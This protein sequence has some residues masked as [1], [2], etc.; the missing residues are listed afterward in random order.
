MLL[1]TPANETLPKLAPSGEYVAYQTD[2]T[3]R[4]EIRVRPFPE[5]EG[6]WQVSVNG[7]E[8]PTWSRE[9]DELFYIEGNRMMA[10][11]IQ[12]AEGFQAGAPR[13]LFTGDDVGTVLNPPDNFFTDYYDVDVDG[14]RFL[15]VQGIGR[16]SSQMVLVEGPLLRAPRG[17]APEGD[18]P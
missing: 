3:G 8:R 2:E 9:G 7:G 11:P 5:G 10:V 18:T 16:G 4:W 13:V 1:R 14:R 12:T 6:Q 17:D 15:V